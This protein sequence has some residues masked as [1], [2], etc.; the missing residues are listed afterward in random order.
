MRLEEFGYC[1]KVMEKFMTEK[2]EEHFRSR[3]TYWIKE[4]LIDDEKVRDHCHIAGKYRGAAHCKVNLKLI[5]NVF[6]IFHNLKVYDRHNIIMNIIH[7]FDVNAN[8]IPNG[9]ER[10]IAFII[11]KNLDFI[12][13]RQFMNSSLEKLVKN[14]LDNN[15]KYLSKEFNSGQLKLIK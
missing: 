10:Y 15:F 12:D 11:N 14:L 4:I 6:I 13:Y 2:E 9:L 1:K 8:V 3:N 5:K 7:K